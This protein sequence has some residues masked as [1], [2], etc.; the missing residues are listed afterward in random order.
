MREFIIYHLPAVI[1]ATTI[2]AVSSIPD[3][4]PPMLD[5]WSMDKVAHLVEYAGLAILIYRSCIRWRRWPV[6]EVPLWLTLSAAA[7]WGCLDEWLQSYVPGRFS[8]WQDL[9]ADAAGATLVVV[10]LW[11]T[12]LRRSARRV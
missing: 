6:P 2:L 3:L 1:Y 8:E 9:V 4:K 5:S 7:G 11:F 12:R 10:I